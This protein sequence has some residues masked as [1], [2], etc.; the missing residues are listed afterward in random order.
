M[1]ILYIISLIFAVIIGYLIYPLINTFSITTPIPETTKTPSPETTKTPSPETTTSPS[2]ET[3]KTPSSETTT[4]V[5]ETTTPSPETTT[6]SSE[7]TTP[8][9]DNTTPSSEITTTSNEETDILKDIRIPLI[10]PISFINETQTIE[11]KNMKK[12]DY[13]YIILKF[14]IFVP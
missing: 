1:T 4:P 10:I 8:S 5:P 2:S 7:T 6:H 14:S 12:I 3:T 9:P 11:L 13:K